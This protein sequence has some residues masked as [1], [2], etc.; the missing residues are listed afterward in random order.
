MTGA[1]SVVEDCRVVEPELTILITGA[2]GFIGSNFVRAIQLER[3][4]W[5]IRV[6]DSLTYAGDRR[7]LDGVDVDFIEGDV[8]DPET[9]RRA[10][11]GARLVVNF[12]A[13]SHVDRSLLDASDFMRTNV[14]G[15]YT[16]MRAAVDAEVR[17]FVQV[18]TDEVYGESRGRAFTERDLLNPRSPYSASKAGGEM[19]AFA[20]G[21]SFGLPICVTRGVN[22]VG[23]WQ[24]PEKAVPLFTINALRNRLLPVY[25]RGEQ[26]RDRLHVEDHCSAILTVLED[27]RPGE[28]YNVSAGNNRDNLTV[29]RAVCARLGKP[30]SLIEFVEDRPGHDWDYVLDSTKLRGLGWAPQYDFQ[31]TLDATVDWYAAS[32]AWWGP[33]VE[34]EFKEY[35]ATQYGRR[36]GKSPSQL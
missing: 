34:G 3:P 36:L 20:V 13:E 10:V 14:A 16:I 32:E 26:R 35:Y 11:D 25:G 24:H 17:K 12:A 33:L 4:G 23:P 8:A 7:R 31:T 22:T 2:A 6:L 15:A 1:E 29:A 27:G 21:A 30:E 18:S 5:R 28:I 19:Q 9:A